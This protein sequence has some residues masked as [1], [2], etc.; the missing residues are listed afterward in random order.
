MNRIPARLVSRRLRMKVTHKKD[1]K[2][3]T[4]EGTYTLKGEQLSV[5][6][7]FGG[8]NCATRK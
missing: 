3:E 4:A 7:K 2:E 1:G 6:L 8:L 5:T